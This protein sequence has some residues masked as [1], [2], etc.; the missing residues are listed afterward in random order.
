MQTHSVINIQSWK[1]KHVASRNVTEE[2]TILQNS[3]RFTLIA[4]SFA[5]LEACE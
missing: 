4:I 2:M 3:T 5:L 1:G